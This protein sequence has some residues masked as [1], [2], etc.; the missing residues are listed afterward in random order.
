[1]TATTNCTSRN[2][3]LRLTD[4]KGVLQ[5]YDGS[6]YQRNV[7]CRWNLSSNALLKLQFAS[8]KTHSSA[9]Y[10]TIYDGDSP[11]ALLIGRYSGSSHPPPIGSFS[12]KLY[13]QFTSDGSGE[14][15]G[16]KAFY[17][18]IVLFLNIIRVHS[19]FT[20]SPSKEYSK[21]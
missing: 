11:S 20:C 17:R 3:L 6:S 7:D 2:P 19:L 9:D 21:S 15:Y 8:F 10:L 14:D 16:F 13:L 5:T 18:G 1:M 4:T 12:N